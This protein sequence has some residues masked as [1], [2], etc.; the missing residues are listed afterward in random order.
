MHITN[1]CITNIDIIYIV[2]NYNYVNINLGFSDSIII[3]VN[4]Y[5]IYIYYTLQYRRVLLL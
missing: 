1:L 4:I 2:P 3:Y 5:I